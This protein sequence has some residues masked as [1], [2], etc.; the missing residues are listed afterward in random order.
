ML[1]TKKYHERMITNP[2][3]GDPTAREVRADYVRNLRTSI[4]LATA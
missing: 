2:H 3:S 1:P 4:V